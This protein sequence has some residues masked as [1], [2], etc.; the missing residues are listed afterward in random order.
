MK[1]PS[2]PGAVPAANAAAVG[3]TLR[4]QPSGGPGLQARPPC[5]G[6]GRAR[7]GGRFVH[8]AASS[9]ELGR[10]AAG[11][12]RRQPPGRLHFVRGAGG[13][14]AGGESGPACAA[15]RSGRF[16]SRIPAAAAAGVG[17]GRR[18]MRSAGPPRHL[19]AEV[20]GPPRGTSGLAAP[21]SLCASSMQ[22][23]GGWRTPDLPRRLRLGKDP[24]PFDECLRTPLIHNSEDG[25]RQFNH[26]CFS[27][28]D[29]RRLHWRKSLCH[30][31]S[32]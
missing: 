20:A 25:W 9:A 11:L 15:P 12:S 26:R 19:Q 24:I 4:P 10:A 31:A 3:G 16:V 30:P 32:R 1:C 6:P 14:R 18:G 5:F 21:G 7:G 17:R 8:G 29:L 2:P 27:T 22:P 13:G 23:S 28:R